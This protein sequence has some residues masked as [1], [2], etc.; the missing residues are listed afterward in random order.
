M[1][2]V[3][4]SALLNSREVMNYFV[5]QLNG[6]VDYISCNISFKWQN[7]LVI[8]LLTFDKMLHGIIST[9]L[10]ITIVSGCTASFV[11]SDYYEE[12]STYSKNPQCKP[13]KLDIGIKCSAAP[14]SIEIKGGLVSTSCWIQKLLK[15]SEP[16][17]LI[18]V[19]LKYSNWELHY[20]PLASAYYVARYADALGYQSSCPADTNFLKK[21][22]IM[23]P[24]S[25]TH[26][27]I[28]IGKQLCFQ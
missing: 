6:T 14:K 26:G 15:L 16:S 11:E 25:G 4:D 24:W 28:A 17:T 23:T 19:S 7:V 3:N 27:A 8:Q 10:L 13:S 22:D 2:N 9:V 18:I 12:N 1:Q 5:I 20:V 21:L